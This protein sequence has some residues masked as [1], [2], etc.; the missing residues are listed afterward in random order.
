MRRRYFLLI[1]AVTSAR[2]RRA[3]ASPGSSRS[4]SL[5]CE[6]HGV[7]SSSGDQRSQY[8][9][10]AGERAPAVHR[11]V[12]V[13]ESHIAALP[14]KVEA[15]F[16]ADPRRDVDRLAVEARAVAERDRPGRIVPLVLP[17]LEGGDE[18]VEKRGP[19]IPQCPHRW[20]NWRRHAQAAVVQPCP[21]VA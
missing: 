11:A 6:C 21:R 1:L 10:R 3:S 17:S 9:A 12:V 4:A 5:R 16:V 15:Q 13:D 20:Q 14:W 2:L 7:D 8:L 18:L 19:A